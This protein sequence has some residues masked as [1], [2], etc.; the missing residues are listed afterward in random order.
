MNKDY[1]SINDIE[2]RAELSPN[3]DDHIRKRRKDSSNCDN[4]LLPQK[5]HHSN[6]SESHVSFLK[7]IFMSAY[8]VTEYC[9]IRD[10][11]KSGGRMDVK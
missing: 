5:R 6:P 9:D 11:I 10:G 4:S 3:F 1:D 8:T 7:L 2:N